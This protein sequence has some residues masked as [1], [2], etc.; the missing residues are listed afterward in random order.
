M[1]FEFKKSTFTIVLNGNEFEVNP[2]ESDRIRAE[3]AKEQPQLLDDMVQ[4]GYSEESVY[5]YI[6]LAV[7]TIDKIFGD[8]ATKKIY[9]SRAVDYVSICDLMAYIA[10]ENAKF[11]DDRK[12]SYINYETITG[13]KATKQMS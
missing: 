13:T 5:N 6:S 12:N 11:Y 7:E 9:G 10:H 3:F 8:G 2:L 1:G 4:S